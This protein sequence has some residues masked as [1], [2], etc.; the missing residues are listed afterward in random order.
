MKQA[1]M[2]GGLKGNFSFT[3]EVVIRSGDHKQK[4]TREP[5]IK[6]VSDE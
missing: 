6:T 2:I 1:F 5:E 3:K 4:M